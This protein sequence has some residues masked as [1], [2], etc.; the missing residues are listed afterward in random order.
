MGTEGLR[1][2][3][4]WVHGAALRPETVGSV[5][6]DPCSPRIV[7]T[8][9]PGYMSSLSPFLSL[10]SLRSLLSGHLPFSLDNKSFLEGLPASTCLQTT[11]HTIPYEFDHNDGG[12]AMCQ[13][14]WEAHLTLMTIQ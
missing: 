8:P 14:L 13:G 9:P 5:L 2:P 12:F 6:L 10:L 3:L 11:F 7:S 4:V 1:L